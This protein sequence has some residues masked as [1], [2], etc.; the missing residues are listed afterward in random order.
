MIYECM[1]SISL[2]LTF[3][4]LNLGGFQDSGPLFSNDFCFSQ[5]SQ[6]VNLWNY[7]QE[8]MSAVRSQSAILERAVLR[9]FMR[10]SRVYL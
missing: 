9:A 6:V 10:N 7:I 8:L 2:S 3:I 4:V 5:P 1:A